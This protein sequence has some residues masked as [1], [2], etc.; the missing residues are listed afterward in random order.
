MS[1]QTKVNIASILLSLFLNF[2]LLTVIGAY[3]PWLL[4]WPAVVIMLATVPYMQIRFIST[5]INC[6][7]L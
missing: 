4:G 1:R 3:C 6:N 5:M 2:A 7:Y